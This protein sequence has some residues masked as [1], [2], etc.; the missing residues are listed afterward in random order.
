MKVL[1]IGLFYATSLVGCCNSKAVEVRADPPTSVLVLTP[2]PAPIPNP[3]HARSKSYSPRVEGVDLY[4][5][6]AHIEAYKRAHPSIVSSIQRR[7]GSDTGLINAEIMKRHIR[8]QS[9]DISHLLP[10]MK[11]IIG[12]P[13]PIPD[14]PGVVTT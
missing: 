11:H 13:D 4:R 14:L 10:A 6:N 5:A 1:L 9:R 12:A 8:I 2:L 7:V 3:I